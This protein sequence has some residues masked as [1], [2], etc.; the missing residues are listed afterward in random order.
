LTR[1]LARILGFSVEEL[2]PDYG[3]EQFQKGFVAL[4]FYGYMI[5][6]YFMGQMSVDREDQVDYKVMSQ[7]NIRK[8]AHAS[9]SVG[10]ELVSHKLAE[11][12]KHL[13]SKDAI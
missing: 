11:I 9:L 5:C 1:T 3:L 2:L 7:R 13:A 8:L 12:L 4:G 6:S 10:G